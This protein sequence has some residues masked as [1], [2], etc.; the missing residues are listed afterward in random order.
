MF[1]LL[2]PLL[3]V[4]TLSSGR[5]T[6]HVEPSQVHRGHVVHVFGKVPGCPAPD[7]VSLLS[8]AFSHAKD[9]AGVPVVFARVG[10]GTSS[11]SI[12]TRIPSTRKP[13]RYT[14]TGRCGGGNIG[15]Q[16]TLHVL[17]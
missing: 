16:A 2:L 11:Y 4:L 9:F 14:V 7:A 3:G 6:I 12:D 5:P 15:V 1:S 8:G 17:R 10:K 13:G